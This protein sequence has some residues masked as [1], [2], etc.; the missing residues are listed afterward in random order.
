MGAL[1]VIRP[2][3]LFALEDVGNSGPFRHGL[4]VL[5]LPLACFIRVLKHKSRRFDIRADFAANS[6]TE[7]RV[8]LGILVIRFNMASVGGEIMEASA[9][10]EMVEICLDIF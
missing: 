8:H 1:A 4:D 7:R 10:S 3:S 5:V 6:L 9:I 2:A